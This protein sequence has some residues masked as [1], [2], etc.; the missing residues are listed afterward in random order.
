MKKQILNE[1]VNPDIPK[2]KKAI[3]LGCLPLKGSEDL[4]SKQPANPL[5]NTSEGRVG[6]KF[7]NKNDRT[8]YYYADMTWVAPATNSKPKAK[9]TWTCDGLVEPPKQDPNEIGVA[10]AIPMA[11]SNILSKY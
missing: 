4:K 6:F 2:L 11:P 10:T 1:Q 5:V 3:T 8:I 9:G 7:I